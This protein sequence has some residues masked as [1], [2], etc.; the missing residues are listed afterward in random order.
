[1]LDLLEKYKMSV[2]TSIYGAKT[3]IQEI[4]TK[5]K[6]SFQRTM[7]AV[8]KLRAR[9]IPVRY[10]LTVMKQNQDYVEET[11]EFLKKMGAKNPGFDVARPCGRANDDELVPNKYRWVRDNPSFFQ[12]DKKEFAKRYRGNDCWQGKISV[13]STGDVMPCIMQRAEP[14][15]N[16]K[17][18]SLKGIIEGGIQ[19]YWALSRDKIDVCKDCEY[20]YACRDCRP[21]SYGP[22]DQL[23]AKDPNCL[24]DPFKGE[25]VKNDSN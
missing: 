3:Q 16:V 20:R 19:T 22:T 1:M 25:F 6:G 24:Y 4:V 21:V 5:Q 11:M 18:K 13:S 23:V 10:G 15:G 17:E 9:N 2:A 7:K 14:G 12:V 8:E